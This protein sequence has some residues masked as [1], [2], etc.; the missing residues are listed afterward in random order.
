MSDPNQSVV[1]PAAN[2][3]GAALAEAP[4]SENPGNT[5]DEALKVFAG[6]LAFATSEDELKTIFSEAG[7]V[8]QATIITRGT[9]SLGYGFVTYSSEAEAQKAVQLLDKREVGGRQISVESAKPQAPHVEGAAR[10]S[11]KKKSEKKAQSS[12]ARAA[13]RPRADDGEEGGADNDEVKK[14]GADANGDG[15]AKTSKSQRKKK[16]SKAKAERAEGEANGASGESQPKEP[17]AKRQ[18]RGAP[19]G[20]PSQTLVF[21][22]NL[23]FETT[24]DTLKAAFEQDYKI[25]SAHVVKR[26]GGN[27]SK[28]FGF[29]DFADHAEQQRAIEA[30]QGKEIDGRTISLKVAVQDDRDSIKPEAD[31]DAAPAVKQEASATA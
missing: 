22:A 13:R 24:D 16:A 6:N 21:V 25:K 5:G 10:K 7:T 20:E 11:A 9:R 2:I 17:K 27:R 15:T 3:N 29:V 18:P 30:A 31:G 1:D 23:A 12:G 19:T 26:K 4:A 28:G 14:E 8:T